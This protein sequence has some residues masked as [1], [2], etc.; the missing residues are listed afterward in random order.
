MKNTPPPA[1]ERTPVFD[2]YEKLIR[3]VCAEAKEIQGHSELGKVNFYEGPVCPQSVQKRQSVNGTIWSRF[4]R[5]LEDGPAQLTLHIVRDPEA[6]HIGL[7]RGESEDDYQFNY[8]WQ[9]VPPYQS[10]NRS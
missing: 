9:T 5:L 10:A 1:T 4:A 3:G 6:T 8:R 7:E 2:F